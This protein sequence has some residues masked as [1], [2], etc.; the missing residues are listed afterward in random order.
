MRLKMRLHHYTS[1]QLSFSECSESRPREI[2][3]NIARWSSSFL[4]KRF[5]IAQISSVRRRRRTAPKRL[6]QGNFDWV[7]VCMYLS[8]ARSR[9]YRS[10]CLQV[11]IHFAA[12]FLDLQVLHIF[13]PFQVQTFTKTSNQ[14]FG[15]QFTLDFLRSMLW[16]IQHPRDKYCSE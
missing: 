9:L 7:G 10:R 5:G 6:Q 2:C 15:I 3:S 11:N 8:E 16:R 4:E 1:K 13:T 14:M 12:L